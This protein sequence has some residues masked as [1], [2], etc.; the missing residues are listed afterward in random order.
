MDVLKPTQRRK[1]KVVKMKSRM[2]EQDQFT[3]K[4]LKKKR[5]E[6]HLTKN[7]RIHVISRYYDD[8]FEMGYDTPA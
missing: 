3:I 6:K 5:R 7:Q 8:D 2:E 1:T 4:K